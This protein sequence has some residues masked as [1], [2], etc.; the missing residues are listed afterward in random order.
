MRIDVVQLRKKNAKQ[1]IHFIDYFC[2]YDLV[3]LESKTLNKAFVSL[4]IFH[5]IASV[6]GGLIGGPRA[7]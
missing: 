6:P 4:D 2:A 3:Q 7:C 5:D 1:R